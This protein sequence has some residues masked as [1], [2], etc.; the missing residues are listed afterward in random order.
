MLTNILD[1]DEMASMYAKVPLTL[2]L[3]VISAEFLCKLFEPRSGLTKCQARSGIKLFDTDGISES[4]FILKKSPA[5][6]VFLFAFGL[7]HC[8]MY[9]V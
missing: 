2:Y 3:Q 1:P 5:K 8:L 6:N 7:K 9:K 4:F